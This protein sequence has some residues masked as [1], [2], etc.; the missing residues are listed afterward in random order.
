[1]VFKRIFILIVLTLLIAPMAF[2]SLLSLESLPDNSLNTFYISKN[3]FKQIFFKVSDIEQSNNYKAVYDLKVYS[4]NL[5]E[6][7]LSLS[8]KEET[9][10]SSAPAYFSLNIRSLNFTNQTLNLKITVTI[11]DSLQNI[12]DNDYVFIKLIANNS[13]YEFVNTADKSVPVSSGYS[14]SRDKMVLLNIYD[15]DSII[16]K[17]HVNNTLS[18]GLECFSDNNSLDIDLRYQGNN[19]YVLEVST[20]KDLSEKRDLSIVN[21]KSFYKEDILYLKPIYVNILDRNPT[22]EI[23]KEEVVVKKESRLKTIL[24]NILEKLKK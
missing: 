18:Y 16:I 15:K 5:N 20:F 12:V 24:N 7:D 17:N 6:I 23:P 3:N 9:Y 14:M 8:K 2:A 4:D 19:T 21:C 22:I 10:V 11:Y 13:E 1:M